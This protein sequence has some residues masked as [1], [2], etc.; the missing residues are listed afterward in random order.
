MSTIEVND[1]VQDV[2]GN[3]GTVDKIEYINGVRTITLDYKYRL[4]KVTIRK[5]DIKKEEL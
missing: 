3:F 4:G 5:T 1:V 2:Y